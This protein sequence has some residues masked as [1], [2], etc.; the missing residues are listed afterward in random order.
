MVRPC[1]LASISASIS[2]RLARQFTGASLFPRQS[3]ECP[4]P[5][6][7]ARLTGIT[8]SFFDGNIRRRAKIPWLIRGAFGLAAGQFSAHY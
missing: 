5:V 8:P 6:Q 7:R 2:Q 4:R 1:C 3:A